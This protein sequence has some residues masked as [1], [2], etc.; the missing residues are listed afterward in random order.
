M[1]RGRRRWWGLGVLGLLVYA[2]IPL[3]GLALD[4]SAGG[5]PA[6]GPLQ[7]VSGSAVSVPA[8]V[9]KPVDFA[10]VS[11]VNPTSSPIVL[12]RLTFRS[13]S[14][15]LRV[16]GMFVEVARSG[17]GSGA[18]YGS[19]P[20]Q[21]IVGGVWQP[22]GGAVLPA[23]SAGPAGALGELA[24]GVEGLRPGVWTASGLQVRYGW[25]GAQYVATFSDGMTVCVATTCP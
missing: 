6:G 8:A 10:F 18:F 23:R 22:V 7:G 1:R 17:R 4:G 24:V 2:G 14:G 11:F 9:G 15:N 21:G 16:V 19:P 25:Q 20:P 5:V 12:E 3:V 13:S